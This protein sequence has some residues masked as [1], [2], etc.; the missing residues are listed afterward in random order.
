[1]K[2]RGLGRR[3]LATLGVISGTVHKIDVEPAVI[4]IIQKAYARS[5]GL[6]DEFLFRRAHDVLPRS[7]TGLAGN[8]FE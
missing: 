6:D 8:V 7:Q 5:I 4:V 2:E 1:M 3:H